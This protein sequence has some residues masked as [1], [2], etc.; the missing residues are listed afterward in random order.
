M[1]QN[2]AAFASHTEFVTSRLS[3]LH[4]LGETIK[5]Q[6][7]TLVVKHEQIK[8]EKEEWDKIK[9][10]ALGFASP[11]SSNSGSYFPPSATAAAASAYLQSPSSTFMTYNLPSEY[12][13]GSLNLMGWRPLNVK[14]SA[15]DMKILELQQAGKRSKELDWDTSAQIPYHERVFDNEGLESM[16]DIIDDNGQENEDLV[17]TLDE[18]RQ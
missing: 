8:K 13:S 10:K 17:P 6:S 11:S 15:A 2:Q 7:D 5:S 9:E 1:K 14:F 4:Q 18:E 3:E 16:F 12:Y